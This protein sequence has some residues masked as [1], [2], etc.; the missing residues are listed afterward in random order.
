MKL[1]LEQILNS[2]VPY[3]ELQTLKLMPKTSLQVYKL[4]KEIDREWEAYRT[5]SRGIYEKYGVIESEV[6][7]NLDGLSPENRAALIA[8]L[9][10]LIKCEV[11]VKDLKIP[12]EVLENSSNLISPNTIGPLEWMF[13]FE[14]E[15]PQ[16]QPKPKKKK[17]TA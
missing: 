15:V 3:R 1:T 11:E 10:E 17:A 5:V 14:E 9:D 13:E 6:G 12:L 16:G 8:E 4:G 2:V 7:Y